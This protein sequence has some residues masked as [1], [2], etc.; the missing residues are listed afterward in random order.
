MT[1]SLKNDSP[2]IGRLLSQLTLEEKCLLLGGKNE[3]FLGTHQT[4]GWDDIRMADGPV[5]VRN[6][7]MSTAYPANIGLAAS[8]NLSLAR[9]FGEALGR[10]SRARGVHILLAPGVNIYR[11]PLCG[12]NFEY[13]GEDPVLSG[14]LATAEIQ[15][16]HSQGVAATIKHFACNNQEFSRYWLS[17]D[18]D[19]KTLREIYLRAFEIAVKD[20]PAWCVMGSYNPINGT[21]ASANDYLN[22]HVLKGEW[23]FPGL[24][25]SDWHATH[26][27]L[28]AANG[29]LDLEMPRGE[30][31]N[32][33]TLSPLLASGKILEATIDDKIRR[34][35]RL[36]F[37]FGWDQGAQRDESIP[38]D[39]PASRQTALDLAREG[40]VLL[41][42]EAGLLPLDRAGIKTLVVIG[43]NAHPA[44]VGGA[45]SSRTEP[46]ASTSL[47]DGLK[48][49]VGPD[50][51][52]VEIPWENP[53]EYLENSSFPE[54]VTLQYFH[55]RGEEVD[56][57]PFRSET[58]DRIALAWPEDQSAEGFG[59]T[60]QVQATATLRPQQSGRHLFFLETA[61]G[62]VHS[63][64]IVRLDGRRLLHVG[65][66]NCCSFEVELVAGQ[67]HTLEI[68][69]TLQTIS[70]LRFGWGPWK[71]LFTDEARG[72]IASADAVVA[73]VGFCVTTSE[74]EAFDRPYALTGR[75]EELLHLAADL[76]S[77]VI[78]ILYAGGSVSTEGWLERI[79]A[80]LH[81][82]YPG[83]EG[84]TALAEIL[85]GDVNPSGKLPI[86]FEKRW[87]ECAAYPNYPT[88]DQPGN[89]R[90]NEG[91]FVGYRW[92]DKKQI[93]PLYP[94]GY[95][96]S[97][98]SF[99]YRELTIE[100]TGNA[101]EVSLTVTNTGSRA[102]AES[103]QIYVGSG[104]DERPVRELKGFDKVFL[105]AGES[106]RLAISIPRHLLPHW[107]VEEQRWAE[108]KG[109]LKVE[110]AA[111]SRD[112]RL[113][114]SIDWRS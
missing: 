72:L 71:P 43:P 58:R 53:T 18:V 33:E 86:S 90:Y 80:F 95:G 29:G 15:G 30:N 75:Q 51:R 42:N 20:A 73:A 38:K 60:I 36:V 107:S 56:S 108:V 87:E 105:K 14:L 8:W 84:G 96:L 62:G 28:A 69:A 85:F 64:T 109:S 110:A 26:D 111:S 27:G 3:F 83:Q 99:D 59:A 79:P 82:W 31:L 32:W 94:F 17:S 66:G 5:G 106:H 54:G 6:E 34:M 78:A 112:I 55:R 46:F 74:G 41:K 52:V 24:L 100:Q 67:N 13:L 7:G 102:G 25:M 113:S 114:G 65:R 77:S 89:N 2:K 63:R 10:D 47:L 92:F 97:Y 98:T 12:R 40:I 104:G 35:L 16:I 21:H 91:V 76:N 23:Q 19:V 93:E 88:D 45:G 68:A 22:N 48:K 101:L 49:L 50:V 4:F 103:V 11:S 39:A 61:E 44:I 1:F 57:T 37:A 70:R 81:A 9:R